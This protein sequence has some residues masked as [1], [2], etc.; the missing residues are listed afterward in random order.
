MPGLAPGWTAPTEPVRQY[1]SSAFLLS[2]VLRRYPPGR[3]PV[4]VNIDVL[5]FNAQLF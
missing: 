1:Q 2:V 5:V 3:F 4:L